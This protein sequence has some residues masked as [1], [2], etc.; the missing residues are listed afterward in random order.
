MG[1][2]HYRR[3]N[4]IFRLA[5]QIASQHFKQPLNLDLRTEP[6]VNPVAE[7]PDDA[8]NIQALQKP[9]RNATVGN[10]P[11][12]NNSD[13]ESELEELQT[14]LDRHTAARAKGKLKQ[15]MHDT[16]CFP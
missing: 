6:Q 5:I 4:D 15:G 9:R 11:G 7:A 1:E 13:D 14:L 12:D 8:E 16:A 2:Y 3:G 10:G